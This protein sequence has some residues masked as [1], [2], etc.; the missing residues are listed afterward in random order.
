MIDDWITFRDSSGQQV[1][2]KKEDIK[3]ITFAPWN[4]AD[5]KCRIFF[6]LTVPPSHAEVDRETATEVSKKIKQ[7][8]TEN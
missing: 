6:S 8:P 1:E 3:M 5:G 7:K 4:Q 2:I